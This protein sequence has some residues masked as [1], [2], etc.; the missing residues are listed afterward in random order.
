MDKLTVYYDG[1]CP[2]CA[3]EIG[4]YQRRAGGDDVCWIDISEQQG[5]EVA[6]GLSRDAAMARFHVRNPDGTLE[7]GGAAFSRLW[8]A[9]PGFRLLGRVARLAPIAWLL[10]RAYNLFLRF[11]PRLQRLAAGRGDGTPR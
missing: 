9:M 8:T 2:L 1:A 7:S 6:P 3:R 11:R 5:D 10:D 4:F